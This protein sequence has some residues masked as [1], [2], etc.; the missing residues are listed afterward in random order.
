VGALVDDGYFPLVLGGDCSILIGN[1][2]ALSE[3]GRFGLIFVDGH[4]DFR[5]LGNAESVGAAAGEDLAI[6]T[7]RGGSLSTLGSSPV[8]VADRDLVVL[9]IR[10]DD[11]YREELSELGIKTYTAEDMRGRCTAIAGE[12]VDYLRNAN[13][14]GYWIHV[15]VDALD[16]SVMP[17]ADCP[18][19]HG[20]LWDDLTSLLTPLLDSPLAVGM[21]LTVFDPDLDPDGAIARALT[22]HLVK[23]FYPSAAMSRR[24]V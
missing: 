13:V 20:L 3:R 21:E 14:D 24:E 1:V 12:T 15:D 19:P 10:T 22:Q 11:E 2:L 7:G 16:E 6:V 18:E 4:S 9:A 17:A 5:H 8:Y 23:A